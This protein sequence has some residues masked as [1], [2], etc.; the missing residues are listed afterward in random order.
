MRLFFAVFPPPEV[1][2]LAYRAADPLRIGHDAVAWVKRE[3]LH[4]T[5]RFLGEVEDAAAEKAAGA[6]RETAAART[7]FGAALG[8]FGAFPTAKRAR[9]IWVGMLQGAEPMR[10]LAGALDDAL[11]RQGFEPSDQAFEPH[12]TLGR[13]RAAGDWTTRLLDAP[14]VEARFQVD[15]L[16][17]VRSVLSPGG[18]TYE[19]IGEAPLKE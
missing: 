17:L 3:N 2:K 8:G 9:V 18:S 13:V 1:Q 4:V 10:L 14:S 11:T 12:L 7:R 6:M 5:M 16:R 19:V 15:R